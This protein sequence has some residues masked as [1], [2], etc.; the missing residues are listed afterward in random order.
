MFRWMKAFADVLGRALSSAAGRRS[1]GKVAD[2]SRH[3][4]RRR[5]ANAFAAPSAVPP[6]GRADARCSRC[7]KAV[8]RLTFYADESGRPAGF[9][10]SCEVHA[11]KRGLLPL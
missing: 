6:A 1:A 7:R 2:L 9:C 3:R 11:K 4:R 5:L 8:R 10:K